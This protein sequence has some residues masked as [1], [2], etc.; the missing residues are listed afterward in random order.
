M[1]VRIIKRP[2]P[3]CQ[4]R[5]M[6]EIPFS[7]NDDDRSALISRGLEGWYRGRAAVRLNDRLQQWVN[8]VGWEAKE[9]LIGN[10]HRQWGN[11]S[12]DGKLRFN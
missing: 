5:S 3:L 4:W 1:T 11:C 12:P 6:V 7:L 8:P 2:C 9:V 10:Q